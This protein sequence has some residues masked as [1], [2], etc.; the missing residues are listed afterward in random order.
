[1]NAVLAKQA[2]VGSGEGNVL[3][4]RERRRKM[5]QAVAQTV[6]GRSLVELTLDVPR[7]AE[8]DE[9]FGHLFR[10]G[11]ERLQQELGVAPTE[12]REDAVGHYGLFVTG[13]PALLARKRAC[14]LDNHAPWASLLDIECYGTAGSFGTMG[15][16]PRETVGASPR[17]CALC[18]ADHEACQARRRHS[19]EALLTGVRKFAAGLTEPAVHH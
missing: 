9:A 2:S 6:A 1:M 4:A 10:A 14:R 12:V 17:R 15:K 11:L 7:A 19:P 5:R 18:G 8:G 13:L 3:E 16:V